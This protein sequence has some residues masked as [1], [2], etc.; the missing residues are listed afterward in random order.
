MGGTA[1]FEGEG[2]FSV[3]FARAC[4]IEAIS[5]YGNDDDDEIWC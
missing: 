4:L 1:L 3:H 2:K 5:Q